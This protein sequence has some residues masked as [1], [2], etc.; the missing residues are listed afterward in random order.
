[1]SLA[2]D[3][4]WTVSQAANYLQIPANTLRVWRQKGIGPKAIRLGKHLRYRPA[5]V[6]GWLATQEE[7]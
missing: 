5:T 7:Q 1:M 2:S 3:T 4:L 6:Q